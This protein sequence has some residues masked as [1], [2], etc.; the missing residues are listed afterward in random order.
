M[1]LTGVGWGWG[2][3]KTDSSIT[4]FAVRF[5]LEGVCKADG[6]SS[7]KFFY[8]KFHCSMLKLLNPLSRDTIKYLLNLLVVHSPV[9]K[10]M[11]LVV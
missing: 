5:V 11:L 7:E 2:D 1:W 6:V 9:G 8:C 4:F 3:T 10:L